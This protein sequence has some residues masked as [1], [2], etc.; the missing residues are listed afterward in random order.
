VFHPADLGANGFLHPVITWGNG[1]LTPTTTY[2]RI[3]QHLASWGFV[4]VATQSTWTGNGNDILAAARLLVEQ[5]ED[6]SSPFYHRLDPTKVGASGH[7]QGAYGA[8][9]AALKSG[10][11]IKT[12][13]PIELPDPF[14]L[15][16]IQAA[17]LSGLDQAVFFVSGG[18]DWLSTPVGVLQYVQQIP[19]ATAF[20]LLSEA[21]HDGIFNDADAYLG[22]VTAW[23]M[24]RLL[25]DAA[26]GAAFVGEPAEI[27]VNAE[28]KVPYLATTT[29]R[30]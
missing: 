16:P 3:L 1:S 2:S 13:I 19:G 5:N 8:L 25:D 30:R 4:V 23:M 14:W 21:S 15:N 28:W 26:A 22:Y 24:F 18:K 6:P 7:S 20:A 29:T 27:A 12:V 10:G 11:L 17:D 9:N